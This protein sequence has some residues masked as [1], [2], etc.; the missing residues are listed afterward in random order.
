MTK[1]EL[2][3]IWEKAHGHCHFCGDPVEF[4]ERGWREGE[5][6]GYWEVMPIATVVRRSA[7]LW[8]QRCGPFVSFVSFSNS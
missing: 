1:T 6:A 7:R 3:Q 5:L 4:D 2:R 8:N